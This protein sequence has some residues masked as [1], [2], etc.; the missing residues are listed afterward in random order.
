MRILT[1]NTLKE[2][3]KLVEVGVPEKH[4]DA[5]VTLLAEVACLDIDNIATKDYIDERLLKLETKLIKQ[6]C[7]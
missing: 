1:F 6:G 3:D 7:L 4:A 5:Y 2:R